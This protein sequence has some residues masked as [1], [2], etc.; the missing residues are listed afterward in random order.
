MV[1]AGLLLV[2][3]VQVAVP[4]L[5]L[6]VLEQTVQ[7]PLVPLVGLEEQR[8]QA[9]AMV[10]AEA[11]TRLTAVRLMA[12]SLEGVAGV[13]VLHLEMQVLLVLPA[14]SSSPTRRYQLA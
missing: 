5:E 3:E 9:G 6:V 8:Q 7:E 10:D 13:Q 1:R 2:L 11:T 14:R 4:P 12:L